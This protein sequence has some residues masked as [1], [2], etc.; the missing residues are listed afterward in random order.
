[1]ETKTILLVLEA[2]QPAVV[3][4]GAAFLGA[5]LAF[6][7]EDN[8]RARQTVRDQVEAVNKAL[9]VL[10][11]QVNSLIN[12]Q[13]QIINPHRE[14]PDCYINMRPSLPK[15]SGSPTLDLDS[16]SFLLETDDRELLGE[17][18][19]EQER[20]EASLQAIN[21]RSRYHLEVLQPR[22]AAARIGEH[23][24]Y[25]TDKIRSVLG[26]SFVVL[27]QCATDDAIQHVDKTVGSNFALAAKFNHAM[28]RRF[29][30][31]TIIRLAPKE[32]SNK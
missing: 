21:E 24:E 30:K 20:F 9:F 10:I 3:P 28:K 23:A 4:L 14:D 2:L 32:P 12:T 19:V 8:A 18:L 25:P 16:L 7:L 5:W 27:M 22:M 31:H 1:M 26:E 13:T 15:A 11:R 29:P 17:L 6:R